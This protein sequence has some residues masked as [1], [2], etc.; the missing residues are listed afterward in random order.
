[1]MTEIAELLDYHLVSFD[2]HVIIASVSYQ[3]NIRAGG[4]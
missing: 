4:Y 3:F 1:M 2:F